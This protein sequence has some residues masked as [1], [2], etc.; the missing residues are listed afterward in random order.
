[1]SA[2]L[3]HAMSLTRLQ[4]DEFCMCNV[5]ICHLLVLCT[6]HGG[7]QCGIPRA[8]V[9]VHGELSPHCVF[10]PD[11]PL[12]LER[13][14]RP[15][16]LC[17]RLRGNTTQLAHSTGQHLHTRLILLKAVLRPPARRPA[18]EFGILRFIQRPKL[19]SRER[20]RPQGR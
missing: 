16:A 18:P 10:A 12:R 14:Q 1:M 2:L 8:R 5:R 17:G 9:C 19:L 15:S 4:K 3:C 11:A 13:R 20:R 7:R 6:G